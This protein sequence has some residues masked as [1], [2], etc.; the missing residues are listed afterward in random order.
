MQNQLR[1]ILLPLIVALATLS[2]CGLATVALYDGPARSNQEVATI[3]GLAAY[4]ERRLD[5]ITWK[6]DGNP[7]DHTRTSEFLVLPGPHT[8]QVYVR[9]RVAPA[10]A[11]FRFAWQEAYV[12]IPLSSV[13][14]HTYIANV[15]IDGK[16]VHGRFVDAGLN[17]NPQCMPLRRFAVAYGGSQDGKREGCEDLH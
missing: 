2:G 1:L 5:L 15:D 12:E 4:P 6:I 10:D 13:A 14:G 16:N 8:V 3:S 11:D 9:Y 17:F 7:V